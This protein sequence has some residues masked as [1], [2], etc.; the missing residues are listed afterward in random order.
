MAGFAFGF[1]L[2]A[3]LLQVPMHV[4]VH[5]SQAAPVAAGAQRAPCVHVVRHGNSGGAGGGKGPLT[6]AW[7][8]AP[9]RGPAGAD[10]GGMSRRWP[11]PLG[12]GGCESNHI[13]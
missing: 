10:L 6:G 5:R 8:Q 9:T 11:M 3:A 12:L 4:L 13:Y 1:F 2:P 7:Q